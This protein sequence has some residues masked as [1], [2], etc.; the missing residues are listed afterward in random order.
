MRRHAVSFLEGV[1]DALDLAS[2]PIVASSMGGHWALRLAHDRP[3]RVSAL[4]QLGCPALILDTSAPRPMRLLSVAGLGRLIW[5]LRSPSVAMMKDI[6]RMMGHE[7]DALDGLPDEL[8]EAFVASA[9]IPT[10]P[11]AFLSLLHA[12][13]GPLGARAGR[14]IDEAALRATPQPTLLVW[15]DGDA[16]GDP[17]VGRRAAELLPEARLE[18][19]AG[20]HQPWFESPEKCG[21][22][23]SSFLAAHGV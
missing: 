8:W 21:E 23:V 17:E 9:R 13:I 15:G 11:P 12:A 3:Q 19:V 6:H 5:S 20:G 7:A 14:A 22:L 2:A 18:V 4:V 1:L 16:F 10:F